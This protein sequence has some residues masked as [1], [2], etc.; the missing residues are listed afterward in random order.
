MWAP[1][2]KSQQ[3][4]WLHSLSLLDVGLLFL[5]SFTVVFLLGLQS[6]NVVMGRYLAAVLTSA[7]INVSQFIFVKYA[8]GGS[9]LALGI[10]TL[11]G[12]IGIASSIWFSKNIL[13]KEFSK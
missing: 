10:S 9:C 3:V 13:H 12:C 2:P 5:G 7:G 4:S 11:G 1:N 6:R 8:A